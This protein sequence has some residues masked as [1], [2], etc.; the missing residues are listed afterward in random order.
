MKRE[1]LFAALIT[2]ALSV[3]ASAQSGTGM[4]GPGAGTGT[5]KPGQAGQG[6]T[7]D[8]GGMGGGG[9]GIVD[10]LKGGKNEIRVTGCL[11]RA[12]QSAAGGGRAFVLNNIRP[13]APSSAASVSKVSGA[14]G[15]AGATPVT[16]TGKESDLRKHVGER[17]E[18]RGKW[19]ESG[20]G[21]PVN[22]GVFKVSSVKAAEGSC[23]TQS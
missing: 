19:D 5:G 1:L 18:L 3:G 17:V 6:G 15:T 12:D 9:F 11:Q 16:L 7:I 14:T 21:A 10:L 13:G 8:E 20:K 22:G 2:I 4:T 23:S